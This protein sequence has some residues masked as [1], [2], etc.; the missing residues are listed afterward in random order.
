MTE[1]PGP[2][3]SPERWLHDLANALNAIAVAAM[4]SSRLLRTDPDRVESYLKDIKARCADC[5][6]LLAAPPFQVDDRVG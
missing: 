6:G 2:E 5:S 3:L 1:A 4:V